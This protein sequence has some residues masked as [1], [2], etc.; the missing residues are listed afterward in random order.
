MGERKIGMKVNTLANVMVSA[1]KG[2][3]AG[4]FRREAR[5]GWIPFALGLVLLQGVHVA[6]CP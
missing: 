1:L 6:M 4:L 5:T 3:P 2:K